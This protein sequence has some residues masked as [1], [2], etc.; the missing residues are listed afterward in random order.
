MNRTNRRAAAKQIL[1]PAPTS[2]QVSNLFARARASHG[3]GLFQQAEAL[4]REIL[5]VEPGHADSY[6]LLGVVA[7]QTGRNEVAEGLFAQAIALNPRDA[8]YHGNLG[9]ALRNGGKLDAAIAAQRR[10][11]ILRPDFADAHSNLGNALKDKGELIEAI[12][13]YRRA[14]AIKPDFVD[15]HVN[16]SQALRSRGN[17]EEAVAC[18]RRA[19][20]IRPDSLQASIQLSTALVKQ[21]RSGEAVACSR[22]AVRRHPESASAHFILGNLVNDLGL[23]DEAADSY[24]RAVALEP[25][26]SLAHNNLG[27]VRMARGQRAAAIESYRNALAIDPSYAEARNNLGGAWREEGR[28]AEAE[29]CYREAARLKPDLA[30]AHNNMG[31]ALYEL[32]RLNEAF[33]SYLEALRLISAG[34]ETAV[35]EREN[36]GRTD[37]SDRVP[38][39]KAE[40]AGM[41]SNLLLTQHYDPRISN[42]QLIAAARRYGDIFGDLPPA[43]AFSNDRTESRRLRVGYVSADFRQHAVGYFLPSVLEAHDKTGFEVFGYS[44]NPKVDD[45]TLR[46]QG[47]ADHW[48]EIAGLSDAAAARVI[49]ADGIDILID[50]SG[51]TAKN[52]LPMF[53]LRPAPVQASWLGYFGSTGLKAVDYLLMDGFAVPPGEELLYPEAIVRFPH[54]RF[55]YAPPDYAPEV[56]DPPSLLRGFATF[57]SFNHV[58]KIGDGVVRL[59]ADILKENPSSRLILKWK[60]FDEASVRARL[61]AAF[62]AHGVDPDRLELRGFSPHRQMLE[63]YGE[64]DIALDPFPFGGGLTS[65]EALWM[66]VPVLTLP[67]DRP[68]SRQT[69]AFLDSVD[70]RECLASSPSDYVARATA[71]ASNPKGLAE[72][73]HALRARMAAS[74]LCDGPRF[75]RALEA[76]FH[77][78]WRRWRSDRPPEGFDVTDDA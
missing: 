55:C 1:R 75:A 31:T 13:C 8:A 37:G 39:L 77:G 36:E 61:S 3:A 25:N 50:L 65:C 24:A 45:W 12:R 34:V 47:A 20:A 7:C 57:G 67:G 52:R 35:G 54:G 43:P 11:L 6:N 4:Y 14:I 69:A 58:A 19:L 49:R 28:I 18:A 30:K 51:H 71:L 15:A 17:F 60:T 72:L 27:V 68:A 38:A 62:S 76:A 22:E 53:A 32:G 64:I 73:R 78:M 29:A 16:L 63:Q 48:R 5:A 41:L 40:S 42:P 23:L 56:V 2:P 59:W 70:L 21:G 66:G 33:A 46:L 10:A 74:P 9:N 26:F 44:N